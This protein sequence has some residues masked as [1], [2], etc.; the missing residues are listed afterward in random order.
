LKDGESIAVTY[1]SRALKELGCEIT[2]LAMNTL[3]HHSDVSQIPEDYNHYK[4]IHFVD[5]DSS[6]K[7]LDAF[8]NL[9]SNKSYNISR[10]ISND[11]KNK[12]I[13]VIQS[14]DF[15]VIQLETLYLAP[16]VPI[17]K[18]HTNALVAMRAH[19]VEHEIWD[20]ITQNTSFYPKKWYLNHLAKKLKKFEVN[21]LNT[22]DLLIAI[23]ERD[24]GIFRN[25][26]YQNG[27]IA[28]PIGI[29]INYYKPKKL[30]GP[31]QKLS[32][33]FIGSLDWLPNLEGLNW[34]LNNIWENAAKQF[35]N[36]ELH[37]AGRNTPSN[38]LNNKVKNVKFHGEV[39]D[40]MEFINEHPVMIVP[41]QSGSGM[42]V[43]I[44]EGM[45]L[46]KLVITTSV[47]L[48]GIHAKHKEH[49]LIANT[50]KEFIEAITFCNANPEKVGEMGNA[51]K[52]FVQQQ[53]DNK[54]IAKE[55]F[56]KYN[57]YLFKEQESA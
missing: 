44:L 22:Y 4:N 10:F 27:A 57:Y 41:L 35:P 9:F 20:R 39:P 31:S 16:Y 26:G 25:L 53:F 2:L 49:V 34:F 43:K 51:A 46:G 6:V 52:V 30:Q 33:S 24:L 23:T 12:L 45:A 36:L 47:G 42:R 32:L 11:F 19:N 37:V 54:E 3:K 29:D 50:P 14:E 1:M 21:N 38:L 55:L 13:E 8:L 56:K 5:I 17:I 15:D 40:A 28:S 48:E 18:E 7:P